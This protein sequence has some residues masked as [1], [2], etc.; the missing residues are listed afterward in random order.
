MSDPIILGQPTVGDEE[1][2]AIA[3]VFKSGW[4]AGAGPTCRRFEERFAATVGTAHALTT[5]NCGSALHL[6]LHVLGAGPGDEV[7]VGDYTFPATGH[8]VMY[9]GAK[10]VFAD[11]RPDIWTVDPAAV[12]AAITPRTKGIVAV[13]LAG[14][15]ADYDELRAIA[16][17]HGL[18]L[19]EDAACAAGATYK[20]RPAGSLADIAAFSFHG[21]K[22]ITSGEGGALTTDNAEWDA[23]VRKLHTYGIEPA[24]GREG[25]DTL[26]IPSFHELGWNY[27]LSDVQAA[28]MN[29]QLDR[30]PSLLAA[31]THVAERYGELLKDVE[32]IELPVTLPDRTHPWQAYIITI[33]PSISRDQV[34]LKLRGRG[35][36]CNFG[37]YASH[38]Q[39]IYG[40]TQPCPV[41]ADVFRRHLAIPMHANLT[42]EQVERAAEAVRDVLAE[43]A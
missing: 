32:G 40:A 2:A 6:A 30:L 29:V 17:K 23:R 12:E 18:F 20:G 11:V 27:R 9:T 26:P 34:A 38:V 3:E 4:L 42:D 31:R 14:Q 8:A 36:Q 7:I 37:T 28:I 41:S 21:R 1:L 43:L 15:P 5:S 25:S 16:D 33:D 24:L 10:P 39:P 22:G 13:D 35:V 19:I